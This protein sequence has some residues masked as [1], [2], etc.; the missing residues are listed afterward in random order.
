MILFSS[1]LDCPFRD[2]KLQLILY[3]YLIF[4]FSK[5]KDHNLICFSKIDNILTFKTDEKIL[6]PRN[7]SVLF[8]ISL[9]IHSSDNMFNYG[10]RKQNVLSR[11]SI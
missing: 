9:S 1:T 7:C 4:F 6:Y 5:S 3:Q 2:H 10:L 11:N 8:V